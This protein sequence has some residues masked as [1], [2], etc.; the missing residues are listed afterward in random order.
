MSAAPICMCERDSHVHSRNNTPANTAGSIIVLRGCKSLL[1]LAS[2]ENPSRDLSLSSVR[3]VQCW[4]EV[5]EGGGVLLLRVE[6][7]FF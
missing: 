7:D 3:R 2:R 6:G 1:K 4:H 5:I